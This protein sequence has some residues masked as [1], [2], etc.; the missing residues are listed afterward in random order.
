M[1]LNGSKDAPRQAVDDLIIKAHSRLG[2]CPPYI[3]LINVKGNY[4]CGG[5]KGTR[6]CSWNT[7]LP[8]YQK[9][10]RGCPHA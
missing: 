1:I 9:G 6:Y 8:A 7:F 4:Y 10:R 5:L 3:Y 2:S